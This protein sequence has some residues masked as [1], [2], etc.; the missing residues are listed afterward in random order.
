V[1]ARLRDVYTR[2][3]QALAAIIE[4]RAQS[5]ALVYIVASHCS[6][7]LTPTHDEMIQ[8]IALEA[9]K[10]RLLRWPQ[11][12]CRQ[13]GR[14][15]LGAI[16]RNGGA[17]ARTLVSDVLVASASVPGIFRRSS[18][19]P[20]GWCARDSGARR[21]RATAP[22]F[23]PPAFVQT[24]PEARDATV[25][26]DV[27]D[28]RRGTIGSDPID[29]ARD[30]VAKYSCGLNHL[31]RTTLEL[32][33][34]PLSFKGAT[35]SMRRFRLPTTRGRFDFR[36]ATMRHSSAT[37]RVRPGGTALDAFRNTPTIAR[38]RLA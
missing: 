34:G 9:A 14:V 4:V 36:A 23:V 33:A 26:P 10:V 20:R 1:G 19:A 30:P 16:A 8:A 18:S 7:L 3:L 35:L 21:R 31:L 6:G 17:S 27:I 2:E 5:S 29:D 15:D 37:R 12:T 24:A 11:Q 38:P 22:F 25:Q 28:R 13:A 32:T